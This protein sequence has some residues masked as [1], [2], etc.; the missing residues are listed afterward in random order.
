MSYFLQGPPPQPP[1]EFAFKAFS[2]DRTTGENVIFYNSWVNYENYLNTG[3]FEYNAFGLFPFGATLPTGPQ[4]VY[5]TAFC[6]ITGDLTTA[7]QLEYD[8]SQATPEIM[9]NINLLLET[10][11]NQAYN[12]DTGISLTFN[13]G[14]ER[15]IYNINSTNF[16]SPFRVNVSYSGPTGVSG[17]Y[18]TLNTLGVDNFVIYSAGDTGFSLGSVDA[19]NN[20]VSGMLASFNTGDTVLF[21]VDDGFTRDIDSITNLDNAVSFT[22]TSPFP[23]GVFVDQSKLATI[24]NPSPNVVPFFSYSFAPKQMKSHI[25]SSE[26]NAI[27]RVFTQLYDAPEKNMKNITVEQISNPTMNANDPRG[28]FNFILPYS[29]VSIEITYIDDLNK[30]LIRGAVFGYESIINYTFIYNRISFLINY[31]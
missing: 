2:Y 12:G 4:Q 17:E 25:I 19:S 26:V 22:S 16:Q 1:K 29:L 6:S 18:F 11:F 10:I 3:S 24:F 28:P 7:N 27:G 9:S 30:L 15:Y 21:G 14:S 31:E 20:N 5:F 13:N 23:T 8:Y